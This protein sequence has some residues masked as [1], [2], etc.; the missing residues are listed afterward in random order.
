LRGLLT[1]LANP[2]AA[3][4]F[5]SIFSA[6]LGDGVQPAARWGLWALVTAETALWFGSC[7][8]EMAGFLAGGTEVPTAAAQARLG[9]VAFD[10]LFEVYRR[11]AGAGED[12]LQALLTDEMWVRPVE[13]LA[14][15]HARAGG[16]AW[17]SRFDATPSL[18]PFDV[19][20]PSHGADNAC[21]WAR[22]PRFVERPLLR[23]PGGDMTP[24]DL[25]VTEALQ[26]AVLSTVTGGTPGWRQYDAD[27]RATA[28]FD[29][30]TRVQYDPSAE[31]RRAWAEIAVPAY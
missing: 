18:P 30:A 31:R 22:P 1:N 13:N 16:R 23:R 25:A 14:E 17:L 19:L 28:L 5:A 7:R 3:I 12:P 27:E 29:V 4:Y 6:F 2:K 26:A 21:L 20:G 15:A 11:T 9:E 8:D 10:R 24:A